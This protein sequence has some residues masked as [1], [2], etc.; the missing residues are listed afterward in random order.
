[1]IDKTNKQIEDAKITPE[2]PK[3]KYFAKKI[4][5]GML[6]TVIRAYPNSCAYSFPYALIT[7]I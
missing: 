7:Y 2:D 1:M 5:R 6:I 4:E 3:L